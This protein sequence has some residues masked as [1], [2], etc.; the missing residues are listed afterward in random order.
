MTDSIARLRTAGVS[1]W[2]DDL[3]RERL[4]TGSLA[5]LRDR[6]VSGV[7]TNPTI[8]A[9]AITDSDAYHDQIRDLKLR[10]AP[11]DQ[12]LREL[13][14]SD[15]R[16]ACD[17]LRPVYEATGG[18][19]GRVSI[20][21][22]PRIAHDTERTV[23]EARALWWLVDRPNLFVKIPAARQ[24]LPAISACLAEGISINVTL[25]F[26]L[27]RY[28][29]VIEAFLAG[30]EQARAA[31]RD[32]SGIASVA[33]FFVSRVDT[34][35]DKRLDKVGTP[36][37][38]AL[39]GKAAIANARLAY[40]RYE[41]MLATDRWRALEQAGARP[42][43]PL[44]ASTSVKDPAY[45]D[46]RYVT[47]L[48]APGVVNT[49][50][51][52]TL[53]AVTD[54]GQHTGRQHPRHLQ[55]VAGRPR[56]PGGAR[57][58]L[59]RCRPDFGRSG[60]GHV[61]RELGP[62]RPAARHRPRHTEGVTRCQPQTRSSSPEAA[63]PAPRP[64]RHCASR[65]STAGSCWPPRRISARTS[66]R[67]CPRSTCRA[68]PAA[69]R[70]SCTRR[71]G[72]TPTA[73]SCCP[74][75]RSPGSTAGRREVTLSGGAHLA[76]DRLLLATGSVPRRLPLPGADA[77]GVLYLRRVG[78]SDRIRDT[79]ATA[80]RVL[81]IGAGWIG[82]EV[83]A[84]ARTAGVEVTVL[85]TADLP[86]LH[87]LGPQVA[88]VFAG[89]APRARRRPAARRPGS[90]DHRQRRE[91]DRGAA[92]GRHPDRRGRGDRRDRRRPADP[93][94]RD[95]RTGGAGRRGDRCVAAHLRPRHLR[96]R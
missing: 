17:V 71:T 7:T 12:A 45:D 79:F 83:A 21:V 3:S 30:L 26:S 70:S 64:R 55:P 92:R 29:E 40:Q 76:Y 27:A 62:P 38:A 90:R 11:A 94:G 46:T 32:L 75:R 28:G 87:V 51:E 58:R 4:T 19:D 68:R 96:G 16:Q 1:V 8:F 59:R 24:G 89:P 13:T 9:R 95:G 60:R 69:R 81:I 74:A 35:V 78:D 10:Q 36:Q 67:R 63:W 53:N 39:R 93:A 37:A 18:V 33:S 41:E 48:V 23:A 56:R 65:V 49:M 22:D 66:G 6:G 31:R 14:A 15:V 72:T 54:H 5:A 82:L 84:A 34:E 2:L 61:R 77:D 80:S 43:R 86:L 42:Q 52:A 25:I 57:H 85:E 20:E 73:S 44:W 91:G 47:G 50:P 88:P